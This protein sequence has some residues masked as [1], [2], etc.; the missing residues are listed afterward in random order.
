MKM[1]V[2]ADM[3]DFVWPGGQ[4]RA[5]V[6][7]SLGD[8]ANTVILQAAE[9]WHCP[10]VLAVKGNHDED[11]PFPKPIFDLHLR[12]MEIGSLRFGGLNG[13]WQYKPRGPFLYYQEEI[14]TF[15]AAFPAVDIFIS[16]NSPRRIH[17]RED[18]VHTGFSALNAYIERSAPRLLLHGHQHEER[19]TIVG[20]TRI[21]GC[22]GW[23]IIEV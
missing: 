8:I 23:K 4:G 10:S 18:E 5:D 17:D 7:L 1:L 11:A 14:E 6:L 19:E 20:Q 2:L 16:H 15:M 21:I 3:D 22:Y 13:C 9:S 12:I